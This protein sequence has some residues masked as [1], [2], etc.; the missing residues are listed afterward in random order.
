M[1]CDI[2]CLDDGKFLKKRGTYSPLL[3]FI[4]SFTKRVGRDST[5][6]ASIINM[7]EN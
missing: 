3:K 6:I 1:Y 7:V 4:R 5:K 2:I